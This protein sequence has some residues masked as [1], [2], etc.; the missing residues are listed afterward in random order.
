MYQ[1]KKHKPN[2]KSKKEK[3]EEEYVE[4]I[5][6]LQT[7]DYDTQGKIAEYLDFNEL[8]NFSRVHRQ[9]R[10]LTYPLRK[11]KE[12]QDRS[13]TITITWYIEE[14]SNRRNVIS[15]T[16]EKDRNII[17]HPNKIYSNFY[18]IIL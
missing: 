10:D 18:K 9:S 11:K 1:R 8:T 7:L 12:L 3:E 2:G 14:T 17:S 16:F 15:I 5:V 13:H 4:L 6:T